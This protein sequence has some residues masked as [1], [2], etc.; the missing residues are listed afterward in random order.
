M[1]VRP[2]QS[3]KSTQTLAYRDR[4]GTGLDFVIA[5]AATVVHL[6]LKAS[7]TSIFVS[8]KRR[9]NELVCCVKFR[10]RLAVLFYS[11]VF[12][13]RVAHG[14]QISIVLVIVFLLSFLIRLQ[15][16]IVLTSYAS[17]L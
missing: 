6:H 14:K 17:D 13:V 2:R 12:V 15:I 9:T 5:A 4:R 3:I 10:L 1:S 7:K 8:T 16:F 11:I